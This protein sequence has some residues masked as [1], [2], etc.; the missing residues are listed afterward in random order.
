VGCPWISLK[1][2]VGATQITLFVSIAL[3]RPANFYLET[4][5]G[6]RWFSFTFR[7]REKPRKRQKN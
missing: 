4:K 6:Q 1:T 2:M 3:T 5:S 7:N